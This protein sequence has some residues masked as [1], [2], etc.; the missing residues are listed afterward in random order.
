MV[1]LYMPLCQFFFSFFFC[2]IF[3]NAVNEFGKGTFFY[4]FFMAKLLTLSVI[5]KKKKITSDLCNFQF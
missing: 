3:D 4:L 1:S 2:N 5:H